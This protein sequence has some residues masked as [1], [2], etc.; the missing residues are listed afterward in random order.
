MRYRW[1]MVLL[2]MATLVGSSVIAGVGVN[3]FAVSVRQADEAAQPG[4][5]VVGGQR[6]SYDRDVPIDLS[7]LEQ[8]T[9]VSGNTVYTKPGG[10]PLGAI[11]TPSTTDGA[12]SRFLPQ[13][14]DSPDTTCPSEATQATNIQGPS[15]SY[16]PV[17]I[18]PDLT[19]DTLVEVGST[20]DDRRIYAE[21]ADQPFS[22]LYATGADAGLVRYILVPDEGAPSTLPQRL[23]FGGR[24][25][26][27]ATDVGTEGD[28]SKIGCAGFYPAFSSS[29]TAETLF[30]QVGDQMVAYTAT[31]QPEE[32]PQ[33]Q[34]PGQQSTPATPETTETQ[35]PI[36][37]V[38]TEV[39]KPTEAPPT[40][41]PVPTEVPPTETPV[42]TEVPPTATLVSTEAPPTETPVPTD[43]PPTST[44]EP[45][46]VPPTQTPVPTEV[47]PTQTPAPTDAPPTSTPEPTEVQ[48]AATTA[49]ADTQNPTSRPT[50]TPAQ[51][52]QPAVAPTLPPEA[53]PPAVA[54]TAASRCSGNIG[55]FD[56]NGVPERLPRSIQYNGT[57]YQYTD[58]VS[59]DEVG[60]LSILGCVGPFE[61][62]RGD[63]DG[64]SNS[65]FLR[66]PNSADAVFRYESTSS[67]NVDFE[68]ASSDPRALTLPGTDGQP[69]IQYIAADPWVRSVYSSV[70]LI[71]YVADAEAT[72]PERIYARAVTADVIGE[73]VPE[74][75]ADPAS[76][77]L[78]AEA[79]S[80][81]IHPTLTLGNGGQNYVLV[82]L[83]RPFGTTGNGWLTLYGPEGE[84]APST[85]V[86]IDPRRLDLPVFNQSE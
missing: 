26:Q 23:T 83:W 9:D 13:Y 49:P 44:P 6:Y 16:V 85:I 57:G 4:E 78:A 71:L 31:G 61:A 11:Y 43:V 66:L 5:I 35:V 56:D 38:E 75:S 41:T 50:P 45:T 33:S 39:A 40:S 14:L 67:F 52:Q 30:L 1:S 63:Q 69:D 34:A 10:G 27:L 24:D 68:S 74:E 60:S 64:T 37:P 19:P 76:E 42:P 62:F 15:G 72:N 80:F 53:P 29:D 8:L 2:I 47:S 7:Q 73:Y 77:E 22:E 59:A 32:G 17:G 21:S 36:E 70:S 84:A 65:L 81:G 18:E 86:G 54:T 25:Y 46:E 82:S 28:A 79:E 55:A 48:T 58:M 51:F 12:S 3:A 20:D